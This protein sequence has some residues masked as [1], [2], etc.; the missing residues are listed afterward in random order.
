VTWAGAQ[1]ED[2]DQLDPAFLQRLHAVLDLTDQ[3]D[4]YV[5]LDN[6]GEWLNK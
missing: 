3:N 4:L 1:T 6:H 2:A 5:V